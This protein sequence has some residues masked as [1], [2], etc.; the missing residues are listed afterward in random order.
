MTEKTINLCGKDVPILYCAATE[1]GFERLSGKPISVFVPTFGRDEKDPDKV[2]ITEPP[3]ATTEDY[4]QLGIAAIVAA[5][6]A[7]RARHRGKEAALPVSTEDILYK[8]SKD[9][10][11]EL[12][13]VTIQLRN[14][15]YGISKVMEASDAAPSADD[16]D[17]P[18]N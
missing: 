10:V 17:K 4:L 13:T 18:K 2:V 9:E 15:W 3:T 8:A 5:S 6:E 11:T 1:T 7:A 12:V 16:E 14:E